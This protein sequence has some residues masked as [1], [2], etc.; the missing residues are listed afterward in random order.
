MS[1]NSQF[2]PKS[3]D[4]DSDIQDDPC[5]NEQLSVYSSFHSYK[6]HKVYDGEKIEAGYRVVRQDTWTHGNTKKNGDNSKIKNR[7]DIGTIVHIPNS[8]DARVQWDIEDITEELGNGVN[9]QYE[10]LVEMVPRENLDFKAAYGIPPNSNVQLRSNP[11]EK[12]RVKHPIEKTIESFRSF[13]LVQWHDYSKGR[14][15]VGW[16]G[17]CDLKFTKA[18]KGPMY[19]E[20]HLPFVTIKNARKGTRVVNCQSMDGGHG[21]VGTIVNDNINV[22]T[23]GDIGNLDSVEEQEVVEIPRLRKKIVD[24]KTPMTT[25]DLPK[26]PVLAF[27]MPKR[28]I[29]LLIDYKEDGCIVEKGKSEE[30]MTTD[31]VTVQWDD[32]NFS[33]Y[34][35]PCNNIRLFDNGPSEVEHDGQ[36]CCYCRTP[37]IHIRGIR[38]KCIKCDNLNLCNIC[39]M[40]RKHKLRHKFQ[41]FIFPNLSET[42]EFSRHSKPSY[43]QSY[44]IFEGATVV[45][46][47]KER[48]KR[49]G[50]TIAICNTMVDSDQS[51]VVVLWHD[52]TISVHPI[53]DL[54]CTKTKMPFLYYHSQLPVLGK[55][56]I[57]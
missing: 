38:W 42:M 36:F 32:G 41:R 33:K 23:K 25:L 35:L 50:T 44:G 56:T 30:I 52:K 21:Y 4:E 26:L 40:A 15:C 48:E 9:K 13:A 43:S 46:V 37:S 27:P 55:G 19:Y 22:N 11:K 51:D 28:L 2:E 6:V 29:D 12:G 1:V 45:E 18:A 47:S 17:Q 3:E 31:D 39:Y 49:Q 34:S 8:T 7:R 20:E 57:V 54:K 14:Y 53:L 5:V 24:S 16:N 10:L